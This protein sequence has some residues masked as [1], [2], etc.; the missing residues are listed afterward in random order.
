MT[1]LVLTATLG[2]AYGIYG[3]A[4]ELGEN[5]PREAG[6]EEYLNS[7]KYEVKEWDFGRP[8]SLAEFIARVNQIRRENPA[9]QSD[10][11]LRFH[12]IDNEQLICYSKN[13][14]DFSNLILTVVNLDPH[15]R[16]SGWA[17]L[18]LSEMGLEPNQPYQV[19]DLLSGGRYLWTGSRNYVEVD[20][21]MAPAHIFRIRRRVRTERDFD[22]FM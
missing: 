6:S 5:Q 15:H 4:F 9:L 20:P 3:P 22:Y 7:E 8:E 10:Q 17:G 13:T 1:R 21:R 19:H 2:A 12:S 11:N 14:E 18:S 16:H